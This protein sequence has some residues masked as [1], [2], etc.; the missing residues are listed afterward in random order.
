V[1]LL[2][3][4]FD[5]LSNDMDS[6]VKQTSLIRKASHLAAAEKDPVKAAALTAIATKG[7]TDLSKWNRS[8][9]EDCLASSPGRGTGSDRNQFRIPGNVPLFVELFAPL[10]SRKN[11]TSIREVV[12]VTDDIVAD[13]KWCFQ[14]APVLPKALATNQTLRDIGR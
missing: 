13:I 3:E 7:V 14:H 11:A 12:A 4:L 1:G 2:R 8:F 5:R 9:L 6:F 10:Q